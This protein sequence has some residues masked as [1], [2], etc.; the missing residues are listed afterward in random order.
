MMY[1]V[2]EWR[3][4]DYATCIVLGLI[5]W[6][7]GSFVWPHCRQFTFDDTSIR[8]EMQAKETFPTY[9]VI[10]AIILVLF[11]YAAGEYYTWRKHSRRI[12]LRH[13]NAWILVQAFSICLEF[14]IVNLT[15]LYAGRLRP[16]F[17]Q[18]MAEEGITLAT[19]GGFT[20]TQ[21]CHAAREGRLSFPSGHSGSAFSGF[22]PLSLYLLG[23]T[24]ALRGGAFYRAILAV[25]PMC[26]PIITAISRTRDNDHHFADIVAGSVIGSACGIFAVALSFVPT[27]SGRWTLRES[28]SAD[29]RQSNSPGGDTE[30]ETELVDN[31]PPN[32]A[33]NADLPV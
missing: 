9:S 11:I 17:L 5:G 16:D 24:R 32:C 33:R 6:L 29:E 19:I 7:V 31:L 12:M 15:K 26:F 18:Q 13:L 4:L 10:I 23:L 3:L 8:Y 1:I 21:V 2:W 22:V 20:E 27:R 25:L 30:Q 28:L 14:C